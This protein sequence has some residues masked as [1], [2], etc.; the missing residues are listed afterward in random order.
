MFLFLFLGPLYLTL[1]LNLPTLVT[2]NTVCMLMNP[3]SSFLAWPLPN[4][5]DFYP[6]TDQTPLP[7]CIMGKEI[8]DI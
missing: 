1:S 6:T 8:S 2:L 4:T 5:Q 7:R 3:I